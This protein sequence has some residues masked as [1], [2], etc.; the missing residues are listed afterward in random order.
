MIIVRTAT[1]NYIIMYLPLLLLLKAI[2]DNF[3]RGNIIVAVLLF[4]SAVGMWLLFLTTIQG[5]LEHPVT[6]LPLP[7]ALLLALVGA[8]LGGHIASF[9]PGYKA[10]KMGDAR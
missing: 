10:Q 3:P 4:F 6:Y 5:D 1:T 8:P 7:F 9:F 2:S